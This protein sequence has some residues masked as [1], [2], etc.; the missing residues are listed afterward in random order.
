MPLRILIVDGQWKE[1]FYAPLIAEL[2][3]D[4]VNVTSKDLLGERQPQADLV[5]TN[6]EFGAFVSAAIFELRRRAIPTLHIIDGIIEWRNT[7]ENPRSMVQ[8][9]GMPLFQPVLSDKI[10]CLGRSQARLLESWGNICKCEVTGA[11][12]FDRLLHRRPRSRPPEAPFRILVMT[13][14]TPGFTAEQIRQTELSLTDLKEWFAGH[15]KIEATAIEPVWRL[16]QDMAERVGV[17]NALRDTTGQELAEVLQTVDALITTPSTTILEGMLQG[18]PVALLDYN[19]RPH[20]LPAAW[21]I[22]S[23][24]HIPQALPELLAPPPMRMLYQETILHDALECYTPATP[25]VV[26][27]IEEMSRIG[28]AC[29]QQNQ[30]LRFPLRIVNDGQNGHHLPEQNYDLKKLYPHH[31]I[32]SE[33]DLIAL[34][35]EVG[36]LRLANQQLQDEMARIRASRSWRLIEKGAALKGLFMGRRKAR[37]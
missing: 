31:P 10:A 6:D 12:R 2:K 29:R 22:T 19:N 35:V 20:Y 3:A 4:W 37:A 34:Q 33:N 17:V 15:P 21:S 16:T 14:K 28:Q 30:P 32:F 9:N 13:A 36:Q 24:Q 5:I 8:E 25:R 23:A 1:S 7:W 11:P 27:V 26:R 18:I